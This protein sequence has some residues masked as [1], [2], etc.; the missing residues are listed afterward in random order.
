M[1]TP[2][3]SLRLPGEL[4]NRVYE[5]VLTSSEPLRYSTK[6]AD[7]V[8]KPVLGVEI[9]SDRVAVE[10]NQLKYVN[11]GFYAEC[12]GLEIKSSDIYFGSYTNEDKPPGYQ[13]MAWVDTMTPAKQLWLNNKT[14]ITLQDPYSATK[15]PAFR[16]QSIPDTA[17]TIAHLAEFYRTHPNIAMTYSLPYW[18]LPAGAY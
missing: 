5:L 18:K 14:T 13:F 6:S 9:I 8:E 17:R 16:L 1:S 4:R 7:Q 11:K 15:K 2:C 12:A 10:V 3:P